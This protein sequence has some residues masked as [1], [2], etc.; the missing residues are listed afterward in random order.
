[1]TLWGGRF[2]AATDELMRRFGD[3]IEFDRRMYRADIRARKSRRVMLPLLN[4]SSNA[5]SFVIVISSFQEI[6]PK[7][8]SMIDSA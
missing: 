4:K 3:S 5:F 6:T 7:D 1:M 8:S 2:G